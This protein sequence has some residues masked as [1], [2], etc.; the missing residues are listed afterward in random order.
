[1]EWGEAIRLLGIL[2]ADPSSMTAA[3]FEGWDYPIT[4]ETIVLA[5]LFDLEHLVNSNPKRPRPKPHSIRPF[6]VAAMQKMGNVGD[7]TPQE[8]RAILE[9]ARRGRVAAG[10]EVALGAR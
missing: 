5:D 7:R 3:S 1:M 10:R 9:D 8:V 6:K 2:R 4:Q